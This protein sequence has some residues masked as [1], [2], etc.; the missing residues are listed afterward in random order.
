MA[1]EKNDFADYKKDALTRP[2]ESAWENWAKFE[3]EGDKVSG[4]IRDVFYRKA[5][6][7]FKEQRGITLEQ[8]NGELVNVAIKRLPFILEKTDMLRLGDPL[9]IEFEKTLAPR[10]KGYKGTKQFGFYGKNLDANVNNKTVAELDQE[11]MKRQNV[12]APDPTDEDP[13]A[14]MPTAE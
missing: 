9:T 1:S 14:T 10:Q 6:G 3:N 7:E 4:Y 8:T 5:E 11:D 12:V 13:F 2:Y